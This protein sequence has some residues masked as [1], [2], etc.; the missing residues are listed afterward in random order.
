M[1]SRL[2]AWFAGL[3]LTAVMIVAALVFAFSGGW[4]VNGWRYHV[5]ALEVAAEHDKAL[6][7]ATAKNHATELSMQA[8]VDTQR[9][10]TNVQVQAIHDRLDSLVVQLQ[11]RAAR[12]A[13]A[14]SDPSAG[15]SATGA[16]LF[17]ED[18]EFLAREAARA[19]DAVAR[20]VQCY[21]DY[22]S[23]RDKLNPSEVK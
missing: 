5:K 6:A 8:A 11:Q 4:V 7:D 15:P 23:V 2:I 10:Q 14:N 19:D 22:N 12:S 18:A 20:L 3:N 1:F 16:Q 21:A 9:S 13:A 17:R